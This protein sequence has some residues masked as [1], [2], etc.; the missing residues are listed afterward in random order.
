MDE[1]VEILGIVSLFVFVFT[2][3]SGFAM[4]YKRDSMFKIH[5]F[6]GYAALALA[7]VHGILAIF[8]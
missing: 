2:V 8:S 7:A 5:R 4:K 6:T 3:F 1:M